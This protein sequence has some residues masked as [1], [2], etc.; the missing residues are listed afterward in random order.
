MKNLIFQNFW[1]KIPSISIFPVLLWKSKVFDQNTWYFDWNT[2]FFIWN[3]RYF[4]NIWQSYSILF[5]T[6]LFTW[7]VE[8]VLFISWTIVANCGK[9]TCLQFCHDLNSKTSVILSSIIYKAIEKQLFSIFQQ[10]LKSSDLTKSRYI[11]QN[12]SV[13]SGFVKT[14]VSCIYIFVFTVWLCRKTAW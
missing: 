8:F 6:S 7:K 4:E 9:R 12:L 13:P 3:T 5:R 10:I 14:S 1:F 11:A 2:R